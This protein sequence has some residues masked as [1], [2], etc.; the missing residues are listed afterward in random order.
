MIHIGHLIKSKLKERKQ[1]SVWLAKEMECS[2]TN[3]YKIFNK[4]DVSSRDLTRLSLILGYNFFAPLSKE[5]EAELD[6]ENL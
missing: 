5:M 2:R 1:T 3:L 6:A 4:S